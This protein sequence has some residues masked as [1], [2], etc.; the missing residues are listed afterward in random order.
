MTTTPLE[1]EGSRIP[2]YQT[3]D[4]EFYDPRNRDLQERMTAQLQADALRV[5]ARII[6]SHGP[7]SELLAM[8][9]LDES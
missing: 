3:I 4:D 9:G 7:D 5:A 8:L 2:R 1:T 6:A